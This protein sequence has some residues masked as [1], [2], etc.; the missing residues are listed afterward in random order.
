MALWVKATTPPDS[1]RIVLAYTSAGDYWIA[2]YVRGLI[3]TLGAWRSRDGHR[4][5]D[6][7]HWCALPLKP[8]ALKTARNG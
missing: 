1:S 6:V 2:A 4:I 8:K 7:T 5:E 3:S